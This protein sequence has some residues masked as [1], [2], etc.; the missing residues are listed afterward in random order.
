VKQQI[1]DLRPDHDRLGPTGEL[2]PVRIEHVISEGKP[3]EGA[4]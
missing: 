1:E 2:S 3:H 4:P